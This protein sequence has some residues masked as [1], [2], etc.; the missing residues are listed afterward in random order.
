MTLG[1]QFRWFPWAQVVPQS[2]KSLPL[3]QIVCEPMPQK[4]DT[5]GSYRA[6][7]AQHFNVR[8]TGGFVFNGLALREL[9]E[10]RAD[11]I[12]SVWVVEQR[13]ELTRQEIA[14]LCSESQR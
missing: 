13:R 3:S 11:V 5:D 2:P 7:S 8:C 14:K 12:E 6:F 4:P 9:R 10:L 1:V